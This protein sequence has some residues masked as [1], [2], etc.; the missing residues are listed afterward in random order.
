MATVW[1]IGVEAALYPAND[2]SGMGAKRSGGRWNSA[3]VAVVYSS[4]CI[5]LAW[6]ETLA[7][8]A[9]EGMPYDRYIVRIDIPDALWRARA[10]LAPPGGWDAIPPGVTSRAAG[11]RW[12]AANDALLLAVPSVLIPEES[13]VLINPRHRD[14]GALAATTVRRMACDPRGL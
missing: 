14:A 10:T 1:R 8:L 3:G 5:A 4:S 11:D 12:C 13:N 7:H 6:L 9:A 2:L